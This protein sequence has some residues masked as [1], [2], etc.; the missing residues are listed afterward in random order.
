MK[1]FQIT[2]FV[3]KYCTVIVTTVCFSASIYSQT[4][5]SEDTQSWNDVEFSKALSPRLD[6]QF[7]GTIRFGE[8]LTRFNEGRGMV[9]FSVKINDSVSVTPR[10]QYIETRGSG[11]SFS[12]EH[13]LSVGGTYKFPIKK[14]GL[15]HRSQIEYRIRSSGNSWRY[16]PS[17][18]FEKALPKSWLGDA[19]IFLTEEPFYISTT[20]KFSRNRFT[21][22]VSRKMNENLDL[23]IYYLRQNDGFSQP[24]DLNVI[25]TEWK[26]K[27]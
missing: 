4:D 18:T 5:D 8:N 22:G 25:G 23:E 16:R 9:G 6:L 26:I 11:G 1:S 17:I 10:Y 13:R 20:G 2:N 24:G 19:S 3:L 12:N 27:L 15:S 7:G 21:A 14:F